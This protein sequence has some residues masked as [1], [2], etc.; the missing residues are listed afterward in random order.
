M[1]NYFPDATFNNTTNQE[2][3]SGQTRTDPQSG[4]SYDSVPPTLRRWAITKCSIS[5]SLAELHCLRPGEKS[6]D[7]GFQLGPA[8]RLAPDPLPDEHRTDHHIGS[9]EPIAEQIRSVTELTFDHVFHDFEFAPAALRQRL[10]VQQC[11]PH[12]RFEL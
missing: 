3:F 7:I 11:V 4:K 9:R 6:I 2:A 10:N 8:G 1:T 12:R 5:R